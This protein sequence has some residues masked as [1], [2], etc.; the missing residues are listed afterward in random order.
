MSVLLRS[1]QRGVIFKVRVIPKSNKDEIVGVYGDALKLKV[2]APPVRGKANE[3]IVSFLGSIL[4]VSSDRVMIIQ[5][6][7]SK[8]KTILVWGK[9]IE[10]VKESLK[11]KGVDDVVGT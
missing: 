11:R 3:A 2:A 8:D 6:E 1:D 7:R 5:G 4:G 10:E 9:K